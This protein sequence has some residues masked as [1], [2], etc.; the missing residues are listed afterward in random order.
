M[1]GKWQ[2]APRGL[3]V[4]DPHGLR[5][6]WETALIENQVPGLFR[7]SLHSQPVGWLVCTG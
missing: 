3:I 4:V 5:P 1:K 6:G 2:R 7:V